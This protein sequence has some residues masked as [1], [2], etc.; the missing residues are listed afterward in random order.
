MKLHRNLVLC[1]CLCACVSVCESICKVPVSRNYWADQRVI[2]GASLNC[3]DLWKETFTFQKIRMWGKGG[4]LFV[5]EK[6]G[7]NKKNF[8]P[9]NMNSSIVWD[10]HVISIRHYK[11]PIC[12]LTLPFDLTFSDLER[13]NLRWHKFSGLISCKGAM[14]ILNTYRKPYGESNCTMRFDVGWPWKVKFKVTQI[15]KSYIL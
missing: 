15:S 5:F 4:C 7:P 13:W 6:F 12:S 3:L 8:W 9:E 11:S 10:R 14:L 2:F 1:I